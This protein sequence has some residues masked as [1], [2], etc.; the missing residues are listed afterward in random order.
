MANLALK[1]PLVHP[2]LQGLC[3][4]RAGRAENMDHPNP[5]IIG[6][7]F[8]ARC[9]VPLL[10]MLGV[11]YLLHELGLLKEAPPPPTEITNGKKGDIEEGELTHGKA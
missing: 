11:S 8:V 10:V 6:L 3:E 5:F 2:D 9:L 7:M 1:D 4:T